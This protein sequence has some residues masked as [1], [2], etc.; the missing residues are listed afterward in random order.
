MKTIYELKYTYTEKKR[1][2]THRMNNTII[3][4][5]SKGERERKGLDLCVGKICRNTFVNNFY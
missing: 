4:R 5:S 2:Q 1:W 3:L